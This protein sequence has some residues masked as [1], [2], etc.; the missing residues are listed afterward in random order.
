MTTAG[1]GMTIKATVSMLFPAAPNRTTERADRW[2]KVFSDFGVAGAANSILGV[3]I[4]C[5]AFVH[6][7]P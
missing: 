6:L 3:V 2:Q 1:W 5:D 7:P 4:T